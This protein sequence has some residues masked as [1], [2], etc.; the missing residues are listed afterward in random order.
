MDKDVVFRDAPELLAVFGH[1]DRYR[2]K[3]VAHDESFLTKA[4]PLAFLDHGGALVEVGC[5]MSWGTPTREFLMARLAVAE[6]ALAFAEAECKRLYERLK[7]DTAAMSRERLAQLLEPQF[8][9]T[10]YPVTKR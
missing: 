8:V 4:L 10:D 1:L 5:T 9:F 2:N 7:A 3:N 6:H